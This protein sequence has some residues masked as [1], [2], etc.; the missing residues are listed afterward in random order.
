MFNFA[1]LSYEQG[2]S[3]YNEAI[4]AFGKYIAAYLILFAKMKLIIIWLIVLLN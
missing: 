4:T 3:P 2:F 1:V